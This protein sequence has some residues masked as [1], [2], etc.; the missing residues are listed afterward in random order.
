[1]DKYSISESSSTKVIKNLI[2]KIHTTSSL[3]DSIYEQAVDYFAELP[4]VEQRRST[5]SQ[6]L[7]VAKQLLA[8]NSQSG[9]A[10][11]LKKS[12]E[13][14]LKK[15]KQYE[16]ELDEQR[17]VRLHNVKDICDEILALCTGHNRDETN[18]KFAKLLGTILL[19]AP[20]EKNT[21]L[22][23][24][25]QSQHL[26]HAV[27]SLKLFEQLLDDNQIVNEYVQKWILSDEENAQFRSEV[28]IPLLITALLQC[29]GLYHPDA[30]KILKGESG[31]ADEF[32][33]LEKNERMALLK[34]NFQQVINYLND[35]LGLDKY[36]G[37]SKL[38]RD[39][40]NI[41][42]EE[43][44]SFI[45]TLFTNSFN[46]KESIGNLLTI[47]KVYTTVVLSTKRSF[48]YASLPKAFLMLRKSMERGCISKTFVDS[49]FK[50]TGTFPQ[51][52]GITY[53]PKSS[54]GYDLDRYEYA[55]VNM[56]YPED[57]QSPICRIA[58][59]NLVFFS[60]GI[61]FCISPDNNL[62]YSGARKKL[63]KISK[64]KLKEILSKLWDNF[65]ARPERLDLI[66]KCW[67]PGEYFS[68]ERQQNMWNKISD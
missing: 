57:P 7:M 24:N 47:P 48:I 23:Y 46:P 52:F 34:C 33:V 25:Q 66:P 14:N 10:E 50:I 53:I 5:L 37:N 51:G 22:H 3:K 11:K 63:E 67:H 39:L 62:Y 41:R 19:M 58:T 32:R 40:F 56:L 60:L 45:H 21:A 44:L 31:N 30:Q 65:E 28:K 38:E 68:Y 26:Y 16:A 12:V 64:E 13:R 9:N 6:N 55:I 35:G 43:K 18:R 61:N 36:I 8:D 27:L 15:I 29:V 59:K 42:E 2:R 20:E 1:M 4:E 49:L 17:L 54:E